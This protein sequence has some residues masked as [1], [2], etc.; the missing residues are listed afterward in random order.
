M[1]LFADESRQ[2]R[3]N[4]PTEMLAKISFQS[5]VKNGGQFQI[6]EDPYEILRKN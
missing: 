3:P 5:G 6:G 1:L 4:N 2:P